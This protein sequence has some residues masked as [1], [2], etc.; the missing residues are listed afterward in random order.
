MPAGR[1]MP[2]RSCWRRPRSTVAPWA[3]YNLARF[4]R[5]VLLSTNDGTTLLG[6]NCDTT[7]YDDLGGW[8][9][10]CLEPVPN[11]ETVDASV[12][13]ARAARRSP[14]TTSATTSAGCRSSSL[15]RV[16]R[17]AR[18]VRAR[19]ARRPRRRRGEGRVGGVGRHR[20]LVGAG[21]RRGRRVADPRPARA[22][23]PRT[24]ASA[25]V[26]RRPAGRRAR[27]DRAV[28]RRPPHPGAGRAGR[29]GARRAALAGLVGGGRPHAGTGR[30]P[31]RPPDDA[32]WHTRDVL[33][34]DVALDASSTRC[35]AS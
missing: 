9:I 29:R 32:P 27:D 15:A 17:I 16:G 7:Y 11:D 26:A 13:S 19:L 24:S 31:G 20:V 25:V 8:D 18:R 14:S 33:V 4:D 5:P 10:R 1:W 28:L 22:R 2:R 34:T 21:G 30:P 23:P 3:L 12:R 6:A 35:A